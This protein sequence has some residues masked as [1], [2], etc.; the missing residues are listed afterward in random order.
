[1]NNEYLY[2][3][4]SYI[5]LITVLENASTDPKISEIFLDLNGIVTLENNYTSSFAVVQEIR[6]S[7]DN[8][9]QQGKKISI[10][11]ENFDLLT[12]YLA[13]SSDNIMSTKYGLMSLGGFSQGVKFYKRLLEKLSINYNLFRPDSNIYKSAAEV[14]TKQ[15]FSEVSKKPFTDYANEID[16]AILEKIKEDIIKRNENFNIDNEILISNLKGKKNFLID[17]L[18]TKDNIYSY[19]KNMLNSLFDMINANQPP[20][21]L[22]SNNILLDDYYNTLKGNKDTAMI[23]INGQLG[24]MNIFQ[25]NQVEKLRNEVNY[26]LKS[27]KIKKVI[28]CIDCPGGAVT[29]GEEMFNILLYLKNSKEIIVIHGTVAA[30]GGYW[31]SCIGDKIISRP[32]TVTGSIGVFCVIPSFKDFFKKIGIDYDYINPDKNFNKLLND[33]N[34]IL[35]DNFK[36]QVEEIYDVFKEHVNKYREKCYDF[37]KVGQG[38]FY[39][40]SQALEFKIVD[41]VGGF[42]GYLMDNKK[43]SKSGQINTSKIQIVDFTK[44]NNSIISF[45]KSVIFVMKYFNKIKNYIEKELNQDMILNNIDPKN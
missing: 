44:K 9:R 8:C 24:G 38:K 37:D 29:I 30:S 25:N 40:G 13:L 27:K 20:M 43:I 41:S 21:L 34:E 26:I 39:S 15:E 7:L 36:E 14:Y 3:S 10:W 18:T 31:L 45:I 17:V 33:K 2:Q 4:S 32:L 42:R 22:G 5:K 16:Q 11:S 6:E 12:Y 28:I 19:K 1:M 23:F 35:K